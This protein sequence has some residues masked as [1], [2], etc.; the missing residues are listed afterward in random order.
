MAYFKKGLSLISGWGLNKWAKV[1]TFTPKN[2]EELVDFIKEANTGSI[3]VRGSG[4][5]YGDAAQIDGQN[6]INLENFKKIKFNSLNKTLTVGGGVTLREII[7]EIVPQGFFLPVVPGTSNITVGGAVASDIHGKNHYQDGSFGNH[8]IKISLIDGN[9]Y[10]QELSPFV[11]NQK[12]KFWAT[13]GGMGLTGVIYEVNINLLPISS[14]LITVDTKR[15]K[16]I[17]DLMIEMDKNASN[18]K[19]SVAWIDSL[20]KKFRGVLTRGNH[21]KLENLNIEEKNNPLFFRD[22]KVRSKPKF[23]TKIFLNKLTVK[24]FNTFWFYKSP[25]DEIG[26]HESISN[27]FHPLDAIK[28]WNKIY[29]SKGFI[30]YQF[31]IPNASKE[32]IKFV[33]E[34]FKLKGV[35]CFLTVLK[36]FGKRNLAYLSFPDEGWTLTTDIPNCIPQINEI[37]NFLDNEIAKSGGKIYLT[38]DSMLTGDM[39]KKTYPFLKKWKK[40]KRELDPKLKFVS[41]MS[42]RLKIF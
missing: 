2:L 5:T 1:N 13:V 16:N 25:K 11:E 10:V 27:F 40:V 24:V 26:K 36:K 18:Y 31:F 30:Q 9:G 33:L 6:I 20:H 41:D 19:Y 37:I 3:L 12:E 21:L 23:L 7:K 28:D 38:K 35:P 32:K 34:Y 15:F 42:K 4:R 8:I 29:G 17:E 39:F 14:S 22:V